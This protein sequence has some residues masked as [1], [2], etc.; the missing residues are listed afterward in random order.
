MYSDE[1][2]RRVA[3]QR[4]RCKE[5]IRISNEMIKASEEWLSIFYSRKRQATAREPAFLEPA[6]PW[7]LL[8]VSRSDAIH[9]LAEVMTQL[10][11]SNIA[12]VAS[13]QVGDD[14]MIVVEQRDEETALEKLRMVGM[15]ARTEGLQQTGF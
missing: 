10:R 12:V 9:S 15:L 7:S 1:Y 4:A 8:K 6:R 13:A 3:Y 2:A 11:V 14:L 5:S